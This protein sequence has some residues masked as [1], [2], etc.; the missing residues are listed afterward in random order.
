M[1]KTARGFT[2][3][4]L[5][6]V[7]AIVGVLAVIVM[8]IINPI[9]LNKR[10]HD[11]ARLTDLANLQQAINVAAQEATNSSAAILC[12]GGSAPC[13]GRSDTGGRT[14]NGTGWVTVDLSTAKSVSIPTLPVD[15]INNGSYHY[16]Y[17]SDG[18]A[19]EINADLESAQQ[20]PK[21]GTDGGDDKRNSSTTAAIYEVGSNLT[22]IANTTGCDYQ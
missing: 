7:M 19:W 5:L 4:E 12:A 10:S 16:S 2:L 15:P 22:L 9:E 18:N 20:Q 3:V 11:T 1:K 17:C 14:S 13:D 8:L 6:I 21:R